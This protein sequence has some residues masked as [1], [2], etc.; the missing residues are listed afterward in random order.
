[1]RHQG[2]VDIAKKGNI[3]LLF[4]GD[5]ITCGYGNE[6]STMKPDAFHYTTQGSNANLAWGAVAAR[7][8]D[9][10]YVAVAVSGR[11]VYRNY[12][13]AA[14]DLLPVIYDKTLPDDATAPAWDIARYTPDVVV[15][16]LGTN[17]FSPPGA[18]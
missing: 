6:I 15:V 16:N 3:D 10:E 14:G 4:V 8:L 1:M 7:Q 13:G 5:S 2:F 18:S 9:A 17:D 12:S 11:G